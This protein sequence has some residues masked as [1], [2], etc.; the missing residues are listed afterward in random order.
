MG[1]SPFYKPLICLDKQIVASGR[2]LE[3]AP[4]GLSVHEQTSGSLEMM[5]T[6]LAEVETLHFIT[7][8]EADDV[9]AVPADAG[10]AV[11]DVPFR[12]T[13]PM[14]DIT[15]LCVFFATLGLLTS[16]RCR[17][18]EGSAQGGLRPAGIL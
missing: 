17:E 18:Q 7:Q 9:R 16:R 8:N 11:G 12:F 5:G 10:R 14:D 3:D 4:S 2:A 15:R 13:I 6:A 1:K